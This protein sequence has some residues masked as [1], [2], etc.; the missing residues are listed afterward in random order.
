MNVCHFWMSY[1]VYCQYPNTDFRNQ[2]RNQ[3]REKER[4]RPKERGNINISEQKMF[5]SVFG[6]FF[7]GRKQNIFTGPILRKGRNEGTKNIYTYKIIEKP[8]ENTQLFVHAL[9]CTCSD[10]NFH[11]TVESGWYFY[12]YYSMRVQMRQNRKE[13]VSVYES[14]RKRVRDRTRERE[15]LLLFCNAHCWIGCLLCC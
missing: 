2:E 5:E 4:E 11:R 8:N 12:K 15:R 9:N 7:L 6:W 10:S 13:R 3:K 1:F 14:K